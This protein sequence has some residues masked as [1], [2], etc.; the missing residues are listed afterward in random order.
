MNCNYCKKE[1]IDGNTGCFNSGDR[2]SGDR[3]S[4]DFNN[5]NYNSG[6]RNSG[7]FNSGNF[8]SGDSN[9]GDYNSGRFNSGDYNSG[10]FNTNEPKMRFFNKDSDITYSEFSERH[11]VCPNLKICS[12]VELKD[13]PKDEQTESAKQMGGLPKTLSYKG[14][15]KEY[16]NRASDEDKKFFTTL[17]NFDS[18]IF[19]EITGIDTTSPTS[20]I[21]QEVEVKMNGK[22]YKA[23]VEIKRFKR[24]QKI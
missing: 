14:A 2:N 5:G 21:G 10:W 9:S 20:L 8:N 11:I 24:G 1:H 17:P 7:W 16:W 23:I 3:N 12:W 22:T 6:D 4:G 18:A 15:W 19:E 13:L